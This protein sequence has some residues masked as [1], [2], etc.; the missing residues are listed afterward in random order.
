[1]IVIKSV[2]ASVVGVGAA[3]LSAG[4]DNGLKSDGRIEAAPEAG[5]AAADF[6]K[7]YGELMTKQ[8]AGQMKHKPGK[9]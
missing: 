2:L 8:H 4:C 1:M 3:G 5:K 6:S 9:R 7:N